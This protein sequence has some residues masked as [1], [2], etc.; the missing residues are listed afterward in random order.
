L[1]VPEIESEELAMWE[2]DGGG[3]DMTVGI[4]SRVRVR[5]ARTGP[6]EVVI[7]DSSHEMALQRLSLHTP[8]GRALL[9]RRLGDRVTLHTRAGST[10]FEIVAVEY[11]HT[12]SGHGA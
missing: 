7:V 4:G 5:R 6:D 10:A 3:E 11:D 12:W 9:G 8:L 1:L 2:I